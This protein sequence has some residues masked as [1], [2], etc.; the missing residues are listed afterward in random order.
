KSHA[1][2]SSQ[3]GGLRNVGHTL[4]CLALL[5]LSHTF[6]LCK[7]C[8]IPLKVSEL[9]I[10]QLVNQCCC[11]RFAATV[12]SDDYIYFPGAFPIAVLHILAVKKQDNVCVLFQS[13]RF[14]KVARFRLRVITFRF[15]VKLRHRDNRDAC[16]FSE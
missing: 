12:L 4:H 7:S 5:F 6:L 15:T 2:Q 8:E 14:A 1:H 3:G 10:M 16:A 9:S 13:S 11:S